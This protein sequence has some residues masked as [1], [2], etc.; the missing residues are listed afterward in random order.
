MMIP[1]NYLRQRKTCAMICDVMVL[2]DVITQ[3]WWYD[4]RLEIVER[5]M[6]EKQLRIEPEY[7]YGEWRDVPTVEGE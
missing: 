2:V 7:G 6:A 1:T 3:Q 5:P 4:Y